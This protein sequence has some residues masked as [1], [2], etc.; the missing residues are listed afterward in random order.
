[1]ALYV[2]KDKHNEIKIIVNN[3]LNEDIDLSIYWD[4]VREK[5][6]EYCSKTFDLYFFNRYRNILQLLNPTVYEFNNFSE[7]V[8]NVFYW[9]IIKEDNKELYLLIPKEVKKAME[10]DKRYKEKIEE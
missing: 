2:R 5:F 6:L 4:L 9:H 7:Q 10:T 3:I 1:M 8:K